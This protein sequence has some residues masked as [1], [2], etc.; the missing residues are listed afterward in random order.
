MTFQIKD[1]TGVCKY[2]TEYVSCIPLDSL[3]S[4]SSVGLVFYLDDKKISASALK[5]QFGSKKS[6]KAKSLIS[7]TPAIDLEHLDFP[8]TSRTVVCMNTGKV[9]KN[10]SEAAKDLKIDPSYISDCVCKDKE[11]KGYRFKRAV[12]LQ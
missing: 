1:N 8:I 2:Y 12:D 9:Y 11:Y 6:N 3:D 7:E 5:S 4:M 10:Q